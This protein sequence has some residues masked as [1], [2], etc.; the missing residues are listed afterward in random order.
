MTSAY[1]NTAHLIWLIGANPF[2]TKIINVIEIYCE[3]MIVITNFSMQIFL[4][5]SEAKESIAYMIIIIIISA[6]FAYLLLI[7]RNL[8]VDRCKGKSTKIDNENTEMNDT[9]CNIDKSMNIDRVTHNTDFASQN[10]RKST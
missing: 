6:I 2:D 1:V 10:Q 5:D 7:F 3:L 8:Y 4:T 9:G